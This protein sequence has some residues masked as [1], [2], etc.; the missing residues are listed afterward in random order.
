LLVPAALKLLSAEMRKRMHLLVAGD[1]ILRK[2]MEDACRPVLGPRLHMLGFLNQT[3]IGRVY[4]IGDLLILP[5]KRGA[6]E[7][8]GL[9]VNEAM[10]FGLMPLV[11]DGVGCGPDM[12]VPD[13]GAVFP[14]NDAGALARTIASFVT[15]TSEQCATNRYKAQAMAK[16]FDAKVAA[17]GIVSIARRST[18]NL[19]H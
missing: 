5:S 13:I 19:C 15:I 11:S 18:G 10:Q 2:A 14:S 1:G 17:D 6:G 7:T 9:V 8:W 4:S 12:I 3:Q 16:R